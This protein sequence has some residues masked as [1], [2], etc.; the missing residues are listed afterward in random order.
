[1]MA[2]YACKVLKPCIEYAAHL[3]MFMTIE[4]A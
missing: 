1:M 4:G 3:V 2:E